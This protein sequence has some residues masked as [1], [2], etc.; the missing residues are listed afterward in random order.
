MKEERTWREYPRACRMWGP[1]EGDGALLDEV[2]DDVVLH[3]NVFF[4]RSCHAV[5]G[6]ADATLVAITCRGRACSWI[7]KGGKELP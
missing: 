3:A 5:G 6:K 2:A 1:G 4:F 7:A